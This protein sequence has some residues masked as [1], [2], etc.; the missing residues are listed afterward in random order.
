MK[1]IFF[2]VLFI[3]LISLGFVYA[4]NPVYNISDEF[5]EN[6]MINTIKG[7][8]EDTKTKEIC[9]KINGC[10]LKEED[11]CY[12]IGTRM[13]ILPEFPDKDLSWRNETYL[14]CDKDKIGSSSKK[15]VPQKVTEEVCENDFECQSNECHNKKCEQKNRIKVTEIYRGKNTF[16]TNIILY[17]KETFN[18]MGLD[19]IY[20]IGF[21]E[22]KSEFISFVNGEPHY[23]KKIILNNNC[24]IIFNAILFDGETFAN[25]TF[26]ESKN[27]FDDAEKLIKEYLVENKSAE[28]IPVEENFSATITGGVI[29]N[30]DENFFDNIINFFKNLFSKN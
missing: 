16:I 1:K 30:T 10:Y 20:S 17:D 19:K 9:R 15:F 26:I 29:T 3:F 2:V 7:I 6:N 18:F 24:Q 23:T 12:T 8:D 14:Y 28:E 27:S 21:G 22:N 5:N 11:K 4:I 25:V 13:T